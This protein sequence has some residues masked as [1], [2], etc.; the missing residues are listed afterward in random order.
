MTISSVANSVGVVNNFERISTFLKPGFAS[1]LYQVFL[2]Q[3]IT[4]KIYDL[5]HH[6]AKHVTSL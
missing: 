2:T 6:T 5:L 4:H 3:N 1:R